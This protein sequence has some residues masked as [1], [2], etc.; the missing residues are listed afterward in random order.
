M[1]QA[2][3]EI[4]PLFEEKDTDKNMYVSVEDAVEILKKKYKSFTDDQLKD[5][6]KGFDSD[7]NDQCR[8]GEFILFYA[9]LKANKNK[10]LDKFDSLDADDSGKLTYDELKPILEKKGR[11]RYWSR[12]LFAVNAGADDRI[13]KLEFRKMLNKLAGE[14]ED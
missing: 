7:D 10:M 4:A 11:A 9:Y 6:A 5:L 13:N 3:E 14:E 1:T 2:K 12:T 8:Y